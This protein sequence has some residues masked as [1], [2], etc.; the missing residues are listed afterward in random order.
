M[1]NDDD[2]EYNN[3]YVRATSHQG[4]CLTRRR[5]HS[6]T[7]PRRQLG[8]MSSS[9][10]APSSR[11]S[12]AM[13]SAPPGWGH[14]WRGRGQAIPPQ[15]SAI[16]RPRQNEQPV[17][18]VV[19]IY[20]GQHQMHLV[21]QGEIILDTRMVRHCRDNV[22][23]FSKRPQNCWLLHYVYIRSGYSIWTPRP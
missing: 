11:T 9:P 1:T 5:L 15:L 7:P 3:N 8:E 23:K 18:I 12:A 17:Q 13:R 16:V 10:L 4:P 19:E 6:S 14:W 22:T 20:F 2:D 21:G